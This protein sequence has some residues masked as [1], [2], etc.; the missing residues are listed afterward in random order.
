MKDI[1]RN[2]YF[3]TFFIALL[4]MKKA[5]YIFFIF[6][7]FN[8]IAQQI[9]KA[10]FLKIDAVV[11]PI[12]EKNKVKGSIRVQF[13]ALKDTDSIYLDAV[14]MEITNV[15]LESIAVTSAKEK[16]WL[17]HSF[18]AG[19]QYTAF[20]TYTATPAK[21]LYF[22]GNQIWTQGQGKYTS[23]WLPSIDDMNDKIEFDLTIVAPNDKVVIANGRLV[24]EKKKGNHKEWKFDMEK[25]M[26]SYL[27]A[28]AVGDFEK[29]LLTSNSGVSI[30]LYYKPKD[31]VKAEPTY[32]Y[33]KEIFDFLESEIGLPYPWQ[34]YKQIPVRD[35]L[36]AGMEN[37]TATIFSEAF[38][39]DSIGF[40]D[41]NYINVNAHELA[42]QW[43]G[44][45]VTETES[46]HHWLHEGFATYY[47]LLA[48]KELFGDDYY[49]WKLLTT[50]EQL[51]ALSDDG[52]G[53]SLLNPKASSLIFY[54]K[55]AW[56][57]H[58]LR[59]LIG[60]EAFKTAVKNYLEEHA[61]KNV[62][63]H[64]FLVEVKAVTTIDI[65][66]WEA[67]WL[68]QSA[69]KAEQAF[70]SLI[71]S[72]FISRY[73]EISALREISLDDKFQQLKTALTFPDDYLGQEAV[74]QLI[75][76]PISATLPLY[77]KAFESNNLFVRQ[78]ISLSLQEVPVVLKTEFE[79]LLEDESYLTIEYALRT[80]CMSFPEDRQ[81]Y[82]EKTRHRVGFQNKNIRQLWLAI[83]LSSEGYGALEKEQ[84]LSE[85]K[86]YTT[87]AYSFEI[88]KVAFE[89]VNELQL[90]D[91]EVLLSL[92]NACVHHNWRFRNDARKLLS[93][94]LDNP[95]TKEVLLKNLAY[96]SK[97]EQQYLKTK[98]NTQ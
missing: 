42:H 23:H 15:A 93:E 10:D 97:K 63:T 71:K 13:K 70:K 19:R 54:E 41:R 75:H 40:N 5:I 95:N 46:I 74:Y 14:N 76:H 9:E 53:E 94:A 50:A 61:F 60:E 59:E 12:F 6:F 72:P 78:A 62:T 85:L 32:R 66:L 82:L 65:S 7:S 69:F 68:Q 37:T 17:L 55:G 2:H 44:N 64:D 38:I 31:S 86:N 79:S 47:A 28:F 56:A 21:T 48:E 88:R 25:P 45:L 36:Y 18:E 92:V 51:A 67:D 20:F 26:S 90:W 24:S 43:F 16:I 91:E 81:R 49:Y 3:S 8:G 57:L 98:L 30:E 22:T 33:T 52:K 87:A 73:F 96:F 80:L 58:V 84:F 39:V 11:T 1:L 77:K 27:V 29:K 34:N 35:F 89:Y 83:S 4:Y